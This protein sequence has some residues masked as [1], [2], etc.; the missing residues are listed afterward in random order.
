MTDKQTSLQAKF[1]NSGITG[2]IG[3]TLVFPIDLAKTGLQN[4]QNGQRVYASMS[5]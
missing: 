3:V 2:L 4:K 5:D 1:I